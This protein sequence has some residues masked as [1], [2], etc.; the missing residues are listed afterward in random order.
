[1]RFV[2]LLYVH[3]I[4]GSSALGVGVGVGMGIGLGPPNGLGMLGH[5]HQGTLSMMHTQRLHPY[6]GDFISMSIKQSLC[7]KISYLLKLCTY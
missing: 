5:S 4:G 1:M 2:F 3:I 6:W 7:L